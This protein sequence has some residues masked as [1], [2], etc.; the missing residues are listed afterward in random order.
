MKSL[1]T[2]ISVITRTKNRPLLLPRA[3][4]SVLS[5]GID[6]LVWVVVNDGGSKH[7]VERVTHDF[8]NRSD[9]DVV[10]IHN[11]ASVGMEAASNIGIASCNSDYIVIHDDDDSWEPG[12]LTNCLQFLHKI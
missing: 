10:V 11:E 6:N 4:E 1:N 9:N 5:Q 7:D 2:R 8:R 3:S 12:F